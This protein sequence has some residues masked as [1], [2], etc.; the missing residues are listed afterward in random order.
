M[1]REGEVIAS[2]GYRIIGASLIVAVIA[3]YFYPVLGAVGFLWFLF[4]LAFF[5]NPSRVCP[6]EPGLLICP[7][8]GK[9]VFVGDDTEP[10]ILKRKMQR[11]S[12]FMSPFNVH[13][14]RTPATGEVLAVQ[15]QKGR[16][17]AA[18]DPRASSENERSAVHMRTE[19]GG[20]IVFVQVAG[21]FARR[22]VCYPKAG[23]LLLRGGI[24]GM[25]KFSSRMDVY[26]SDVYAPAIAVGEKVSAGQTI[27]ARKK[28]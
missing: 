7:A 6:H 27:L 18:F 26:F 22:I 21:W 1:I 16:F 15:Y 24:F 17:L 12:I 2:E 25:I 13:V 28:G 10:N 20:E 9:V 14:N 3:F 19:D 4:C 23:E 8:D 5:R 11:I